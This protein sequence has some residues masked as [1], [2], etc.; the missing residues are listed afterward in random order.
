MEVI[1]SHPKVGVKV[2]S[3]GDAITR[4]SLFLSPNFVLDC[5]S[6]KLRD[7]LLQWLKNY[8]Q[9]QWTAYPL[10]PYKRPFAQKAAAFLQSTSHGNLLSYKELA[11]AIGHP[12]AARAI[13][14]FCSGN[15]FPLFIPCH[16]VIPSSG[17][18]GSFTPDPRIKE[19]LL[20]FEGIT[21]I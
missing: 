12:G 8:A 3:E 16:R 14:S 11:E 15:L 17:K 6:K 20:H 7:S 13:G 1:S 21:T 18:L 5:P 10:P 2:I 19:Q 4:I 9:G